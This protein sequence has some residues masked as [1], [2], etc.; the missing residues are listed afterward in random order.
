MG[1]KAWY[2]FIIFFA[3]ML[4]L[5]LLTEKVSEGMFGEDW[6][7]LKSWILPVSAV[8]VISLVL[9]F[10]RTLLSWEQEG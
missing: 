8:V 9:I 2:V 10:R 1:R 6:I 7:W 5:L 4:L 3:V